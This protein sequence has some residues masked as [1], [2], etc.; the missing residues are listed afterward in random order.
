MFGGQS[1]EVQILHKSMQDVNQQTHNLHVIHR[2]TEQIIQV[3]N[4]E[5]K[6]SNPKTSDLCNELRAAIDL[7]DV[8]LTTFADQLH[9]IRRPSV[10]GTILSVTQNVMRVF[11][12]KEKPVAETFN[13]RIE[14]FN[15]A[16]KKVFSGELNQDS[17][18]AL[19]T[20]S[21]NLRQFLHVA[22]VLGRENDSSY[23]ELYTRQMDGKLS[24]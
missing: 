5:K 20:A 6:S 14:E 11:G 10:N 1:C 17:L 24:M 2:V 19:A 16:S 7:V 9:T 12:Q 23:Q 18:Q 4:T 22:S 8:S 13:Q 3:M 21:N 15:D